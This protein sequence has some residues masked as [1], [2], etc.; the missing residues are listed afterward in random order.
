MDPRD[1]R[2]PWEALYAEILKYLGEDPKFL[3]VQGK[4]RRT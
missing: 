3:L 4:T 1:L 2:G